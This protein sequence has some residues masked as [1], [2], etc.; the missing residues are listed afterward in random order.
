MISFFNIS[1]KPR[2]LTSLSATTPTS[3]P[4]LV[5]Y[6]LLRPSSENNEC[7][8][9]S[10]VLSTSWKTAIVHK[11]VRIGTVHSYK[12]LLFCANEARISEHPS[13]I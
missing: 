5:T 13:I 12:L 7:A 1:P 8:L 11:T 6:A 4:Q 10:E 9:Y 2:E 3:L